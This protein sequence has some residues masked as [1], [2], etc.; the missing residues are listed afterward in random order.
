MKPAIVIFFALAACSPGQTQVAVSAQA[1][2]GQLA[3][4]APTLAAAKHA[5]FGDDGGSDGG[6]G[7]GGGGDLLSPHDPLTLRGLPPSATALT[8]T[9]SYDLT[10]SMTLRAS[11]MAGYQHLNGT[12]PNGFDILTDPIQIEVWAQ[13]LGL[14]ITLGHRQAL[15]AGLQLDYD[16]GLGLTRLQAGTHL[17]SA[18]IDLRGRSLQTLPYLVA[19]GRLAGQTGPALLGSL[20]VFSSGANEVRLGVEQAF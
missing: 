19:E 12:L 5:F 2:G 11:A 17:Q 4:G 10:A 1:V 20:W 8:L 15:P 16:A 14:Q 6:D 3:Y 13:S 7:G 18:L 9:R